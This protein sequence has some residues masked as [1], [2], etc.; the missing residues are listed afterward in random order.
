[1][2]VFCTASPNTNPQ[3]K[4]RRQ[5]HSWTLAGLSLGGGVRQGFIEFSEFD[6]FDIESPE[7]FL[8]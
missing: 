8:N 2:T 6:V 4:T 5:P 1:M 7:E 3:N